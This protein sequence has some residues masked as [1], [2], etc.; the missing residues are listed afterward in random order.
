MG[1]YLFLTNNH[2]IY[3]KDQKL[4]SILPDIGLKVAAAFPFRSRTAESPIV[5]IFA[6]TIFDQA[7]F[8]CFFSKFCFMRKK[9]RCRSAKG[10][11]SK[12]SHEFL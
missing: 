12:E 10:F 3:W 2:A 11:M 8:F 6:K 7:M 4:T 5:N 1:N 9:V